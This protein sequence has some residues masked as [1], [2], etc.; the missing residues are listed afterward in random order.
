MNTKVEEFD[1]CFT[2]LC[3]QNKMVVGVFTGDIDPE[4]GK[5]WCPDCE[6]AEETIA[7]IVPDTCKKN[8]FGLIFCSVGEKA[9]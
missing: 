8:G 2:E 5:N 3:A 9:R 4:T 1:K 7:K 6:A